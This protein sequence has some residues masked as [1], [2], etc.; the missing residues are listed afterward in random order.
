MYTIGK[1]VNMKSNKGSYAD[2]VKN[3][4]SELPFFEIEDI[5]SIG[6]KEKYAKILLFRLV[7]AGEILRLKKGI[8]VSKKYLDKIEKANK[9]NSYLEF[10]ATTI[11]GPAYLSTEYILSENGILTENAQTFTLIS[12]NKTKKIVNHFGIFNYRHMRD[13]LFS[14]FDVKKNG[15][16]LI[17]KA[18]VAKALFDFLYLRKN[19]IEDKSAFSASRLNLENLKNKD[20]KEFK[21]FI[22]MEGSKKMKKILSYLWEQ[23]K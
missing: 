22:K 4:V 13:K 7:K 23:R 17:N 10:I 21:E 12:K 19:I 18:T 1:F 5:A 6:I 9:I 14:G 11:Y 8:Y 20:L 3:T 15:D 16:F 2:I